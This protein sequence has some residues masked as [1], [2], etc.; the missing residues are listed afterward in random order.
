MIVSGFMIFVQRETILCTSYH[1]DSCIYC[2]IRQFFMKAERAH[3]MGL[4]RVNLLVLFADSF[5]LADFLYGSQSTVRFKACE[6][7]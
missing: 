5:V 1:S 2:R 3:Y 6:Q 4:R 7:T